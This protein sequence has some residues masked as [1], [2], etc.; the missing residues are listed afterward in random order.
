[1]TV[2][3]NT[4]EDI[5]LRALTGTV[6]AT[7]PDGRTIHL[8]THHSTYSNVVYR[9]LLDDKVTYMGLASAR[10]VVNAMLNL[11]IFHNMNTTYTPN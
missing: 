8:D 5:L 11:G 4:T 10:S 1:M 9:M 3:I 7:L 2:A 6:S